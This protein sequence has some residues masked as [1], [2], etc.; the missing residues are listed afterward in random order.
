MG[1]AQ[2][3]QPTVSNRLSQTINLAI[4]V[5]TYGKF[6]DIRAYLHHV[7]LLFVDEGHP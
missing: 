1:E 6:Y 3:F 5:I 4:F 7:L 2:W